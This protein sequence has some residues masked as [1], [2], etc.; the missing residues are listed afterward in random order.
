MTNL[1]QVDLHDVECYWKTRKLAN[2]WHLPYY[3]RWLQPFLTGPGG[4]PSLGH[5]GTQQ[6]LGNWI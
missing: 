2:E 3:I 1:Q 6:A 4:Y 5:S